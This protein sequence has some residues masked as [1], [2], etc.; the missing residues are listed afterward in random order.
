MAIIAGNLPFV[1]AESFN[2]FESLG[3]AA[4]DAAGLSVGTFEV[5]NVD[6]VK[7]ILKDNPDLLPHVDF[8]KDTIWNKDKINKTITQSIIQ[9]DD[10]ETVAKKLQQVTNMDEQAAIRNARTA[11]TSAENIGRSEAYE[12]I[13]KKGV[14]CKFQW[15]AVKDAR[16][17][18]THLLLDGTYRNDKTGVFGEGI[19][20][21]PYLRFPADPIGR[22]EEIYNCRCRAGIVFEATVIDH[23]NDDELYNKFM[24]EKHPDDWAAMKTSERELRRKAEAEAAKARQ[25]ELRAKRGL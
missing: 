3:F 2:F 7:K 4:A 5:Y 16:T 23:S 19:I 18:D 22:P 24:Q 8:A 12:T 11:M 25:A 10:M 17:R 1:I 14:P 20:S 13:K 9:G 15:S 6:S 21:P